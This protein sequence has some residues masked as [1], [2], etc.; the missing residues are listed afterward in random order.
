M[1][2]TFRTVGD[3]R[4]GCGCSTQLGEL[5]AGLGR[6]AVLVTGRRAL[7]EAGITDRLASSLRSAGVEVTLAEEAEP[8]PGVETVDRVRRIVRE[9]KA[10]AVVAA[11][12]GSAIDVG[13]A[14][15]ALAGEDAPTADYFSDRPVPAAG[16]PCVAAATT[17]GTGAE[18]TPNSVLTDPARRVKQSIRG[19]AILPAAAVVDG[20]LTA[21]C[22]PR[23]TAAAGMD[24]LTQAVESYLSIKATPLTEALSLQSARLIAGALP[25]AFA[26]GKDLPARSAMA[27]G[28][29]L[30]GMA[31]A[32]ARLGAVHGMAHPIGFHCHAPHGAV[33]AVLLAPVLRFNRQAAGAKYEVLREIFVAD[34]AEAVAEM[35][36]RLELPS[37]LS[38][39][40]LREEM[41]DAVAAESMPSGSLAAN[42]RPVSEEDVKAL[43]REVL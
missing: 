3:I 16:L 39:L 8:E 17:A 2:S 1:A 38:E 23:V 26:N 10:E 22:P 9:A 24:A 28:S 13:K 32:N 30:A 36:G 15:A 33:C 11:G 19:R 5:V 35:L 20:E 43:L 40:G 31:L 25:A 34:P 18:V 42:P 4:T 7:R 41:F 29:L 27:Y 12:G 37:R 21:P 6:R 14:A